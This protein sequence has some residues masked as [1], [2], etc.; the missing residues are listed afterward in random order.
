MI[1]VAFTANFLLNLNFTDLLFSMKPILS[2]GGARDW[3]SDPVSLAR[4]CLFLLQF[5]SVYMEGGSKSPREEGNLGL[6][7]AVVCAV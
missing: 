4:G 7:C 1:A 3:M 6:V 2:P 5:I